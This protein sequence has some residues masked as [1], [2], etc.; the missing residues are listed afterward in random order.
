M[1]TDPKQATIEQVMN[2]LGKVKLVTNDI[3][4]SISYE[5]AAYENLTKTTDP[6]G[7]S[8]VLHYDQ[9]GRK[10]TMSD[11]DM[12]SWIYTYNGFGELISQRDAKLQTVS[13]Q[14]DTLGHMVRRDEPEGTTVWTHDT[15]WKGA[16]SDVV[17]KNASEVEIYRKT[18][19]YD[20]VGKVKKETIATNWAGVVIGSVMH[21]A[22]LP[23][24]ARAARL[25]AAPLVHR[26]PQPGP[27]SPS[28]VAS[29]LL[30]RRPWPDAGRQI[31]EPGGP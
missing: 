4:Q 29:P 22:S 1:V 14:Y 23:R 30:E 7:N 15:R 28:F 31:L 17:Q 8:V 11:P 2:A 18:V 6:S 26:F 9:R 3:D 27:R 25:V 24:A 13:M 12:G 16:L 10:D 19:E 21:G 20:T 5:Y